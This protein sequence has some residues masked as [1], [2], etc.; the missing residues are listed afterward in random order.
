MIRRGFASL[1]ELK[2]EDWKEAEREEQARCERESAVSVEGSFT[3]VE[4]IT[5]P[6]WLSLPLVDPAWETLGSFSKTGEL[7]TSTSLGA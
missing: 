1:D 6:D 5:S 2:E 3:G 4:R 7:S